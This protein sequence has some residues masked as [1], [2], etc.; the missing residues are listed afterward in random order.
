V[1]DG[2]DVDLTS[3]SN[4]PDGPDGG[5]S[6]GSDASD[7]TLE[8][9]VA[10]GLI[11]SLSV[12]T[13][14]AT[15]LLKASGRF[16]EETEQWLVDSIQEQSVLVVEGMKS[17]IDAATQA[18]VDAATNVCLAAG[19]LGEVSSDR[20]APLLEALLRASDVLRQI[21]GA[22]VRGLSPEVVELL[23]ELSASHPVAEPVRPPV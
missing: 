8:A 5:P 12:A 4:A 19:L 11:G 9:V 15:M 21:L 20:R 17:I 10:H 6:G 2:E 3:G 1:G 14:S 7:G 18:F 16:D 13:G 22:L 23:D